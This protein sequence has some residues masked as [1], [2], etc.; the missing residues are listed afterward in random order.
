MNLHRSK[1]PVITH[2]MISNTITS[3]FH[4]E[5]HVKRVLS[6]SNAVQ[7]V[8]QSA[9]LAIHAIGHGLSVAQGTTSK[10]AIKQVD[11]L[12]SNANIDTWSFQSC[13]IPYSIGAR[14]EII[15]AMD[16]TDF[17]LDDQ[18]TLSIQMLTTHGR[19]TPLLWKTYRKST[20]RDHQ[21]EYEN[22]LLD[23]LKNSIPEDVQVTIVADRGFA[24]EM[25]YQSII[26]RGFDYIIRFKGWTYVES[27]SG[28]N[29][30]A[31]EWLK[32]NGRARMLRNAKLTEKK[33]PV[34]SIVC[35]REKGMKNDWCIASSKEEITANQLIKYYAKR[36]SIECSFRDIKDNR[37]G[38]GLENVRTRACD[39]R[40][41]LLL[42]GTIA[43]AL[44]TL[45]GAAGEAIG[46][47]R[48]L[49]ASTAKK[50]QLSLIRQGLHWYSA[51]PNMREERLTPL[52]NSFVK[53]LKDLKIFN[54]IFFVV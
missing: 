45:L 32:A 27:N 52:I 47:D 37:F 46:F 1:N 36:W 42:L 31:N 15:V 7:G 54:D 19:S 51:I 23:H 11:R 24:A 4:D 22:E 50:R 20:L 39:R 43:I 12:L 9:S 8:L 49:Y 35:Y 10:H 30:K 41:R 14:K 48:Q 53:L 25:V 28:I 13:W 16:W 18:T 38:F 34:S 5:L 6:L 17:A 40:D 26:S 44:L 29:K 21:R 2:N 3:I 33:I